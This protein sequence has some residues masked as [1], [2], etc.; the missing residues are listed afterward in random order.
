MPLFK[1]PNVCM[2]KFEQK[3]DYSTLLP[4]HVYLGLRADAANDGPCVRS[5]TPLNL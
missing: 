4:T 5:A 1:N 2:D 3:L